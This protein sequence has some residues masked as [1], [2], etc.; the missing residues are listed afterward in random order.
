MFT[1]AASFIPG[2]SWKQ[3]SALQ[4]VIINH[5]TSRQWLKTNVLPSHEKTWS[6]FKCI[7][8]SERSQSEKATSFMINYMT[9]GKGKTMET[10][11]RS[12]AARG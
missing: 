2:N 7:L 11:K 4:Q 12:V 5:G 9:S 8:L 10:V 6:K 3:P 1:A